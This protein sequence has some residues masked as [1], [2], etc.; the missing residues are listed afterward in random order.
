MKG[1]LTGLVSSLEGLALD[2]VALT[3]AAAEGEEEEA[4]W[5]GVRARKRVPLQGLFLAR[6]GAAVV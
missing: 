3:L 1:R 4:E 6:A 5:M 2:L